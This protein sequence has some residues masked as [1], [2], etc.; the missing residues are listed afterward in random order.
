MTIEPGATLRARAATRPGEELLLVLDG[1][2]E[3]SVGEDRFTLRKGDALHYLTDH[4]YTSGESFAPAGVR[5]AVRGQRFLSLGSR[6]CGGQVAQAQAH[7]ADQVATGTVPERQ[8]GERGRPGG[9][10]VPG[11]DREQEPVR[12]LD[13]LTSRGP[14]RNA[15]AMRVVCTVAAAATSRGSARSPHSA[16]AVRRTPARRS[17]PE[18]V[19]PGPRRRGRGRGPPRR[20]RAAPRLVAARRATGSAGAER[21]G[22]HGW[23]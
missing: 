9:G 16:R 6:P 5:G 13:E 21:R 3:V 23:P 10:G 20:R 19:R 8:Q 4:P 12:R 17:S 22:C 15:S 7:P 14:P 1:I 18:G 11:R 2:L